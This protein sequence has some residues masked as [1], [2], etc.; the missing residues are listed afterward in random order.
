M[1][2][3]SVVSPASLR[4]VHGANY[5]LDFLVKSKPYFKNISFN[6]VYSAKETLVISQGDEMPI[7]KGTGTLTYNVK[8]RFRTI[9]RE[10]LKSKFY[11]GARI[12]EYF[13]YI[14]PAK[15]TA[16]KVLNDNTNND[17]I[18]F[19]E[20]YGAYYYLKKHSNNNNIKTAIIIHQ[21]D[22]SLGQFLILF[23]A[24]DKDGRRERLL[25]KRDFVFKNI[26]K[27]IYISQKAYE[28]S[29]FHSKR[30]MIYNGI[31]DIPDK[32]RSRYRGDCV[33]R[34]ICVGSMAGRKGQDI[35]IKALS[36]LH[37]DVLDKV[38]LYLVGDGE[39]R[40]VL[41][42]MAKDH[43]VDKKVKFLGLRNDVAEILSGM[44]VFVMPSSNEG[45]SIS[46]LE[47]LRAGLYM[48]MTDTG[49][50]CEVMENNCGMVVTRDPSDVASKI[51]MIVNNNIVSENQKQNSVNRYRQLF[52]LEKM[53]E[54]YEK[55]VTEN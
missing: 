19:Q 46:S 44:D 17:W 11:L 42:E 6:K 1:R 29:H 27:I 52:S 13:N 54:N 2:T 39:Q 22:D 15:I 18:I 5:V 50:N 34:L 14:R 21:A 40:P 35:I 55:L 45:L 33:T 25:R 36:I 53:A 41:E 20:S 28:G 30:C 4:S 8:R 7:G 32:L 9:I 16:K 49:G 12:K 31:P 47:A 23:P 43:N 3:F 51:E 48:L 26:D 24:F 37:P 10:A 38:E